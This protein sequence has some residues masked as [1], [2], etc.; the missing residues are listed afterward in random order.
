MKAV[1]ID[2]PDDLV[3][4]LTMVIDREIVPER[5]IDGSFSLKVEK[6]LVDRVRGLKFEIFANEHPPPHFHVT[7]TVCRASFALDDGRVIKSSGNTR[8]LE[9]QVAYYFSENRAKLIDF[10]NNSRPDDCTV[11]PFGQP[12]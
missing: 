1:S 9:K 3:R 11:G 2:V 5:Q 4:D 6:A 10:W 12:F 8:K 7:T